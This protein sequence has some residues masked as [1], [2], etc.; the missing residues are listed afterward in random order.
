MEERAM[1]RVDADCAALA[2]TT[3]FL[4]YFTDMPER[5]QPGKVI[6]PLDEILLLC[7]LAVLAGAKAFTD[8]ARFGEKKLDL[9][10]RFGPYKD[11]TPATI[12]WAIFSPHR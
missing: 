4:S 10:R 7:L 9:L 1:E 3:V 11:G 2:E 12:I 5:R 8:I 6:Y